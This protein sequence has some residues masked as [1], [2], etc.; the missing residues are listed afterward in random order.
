MDGK[1][2]QA[3]NLCHETFNINKDPLTYCMVDGLTNH[4]LHGSSGGAIGPESKNCQAFMAER[5][6]NEWD[7]NCEIASQNQSRRWPNQLNTCES[8]PG[9]G[10]CRGLTSGDYVIL[11]AFELKYRK[12]SSDSCKI[13]TE[14]FDPNVPTSQK[15]SYQQNREACCIN[16]YWVNDQ[17]IKNLDKDILMN[18]VL[19][20]PQLAIGIL[21]NMYNNMKNKGLLSKLAHTKL[22][23]FYNQNQQ[24][25]EARHKK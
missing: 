12:E 10:L 23:M 15:I 9:D 18:K 11:N 2:K 20:R 13:K 4:F 8:R 5:C 14:L 19:A 22:G 3:I 6:A 25:F 17:E 21:V 24:Y 7:V 1:Y 16:Q